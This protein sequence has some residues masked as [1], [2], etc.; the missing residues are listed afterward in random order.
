MPSPFRRAAVRAGRALDRVFGEEFRVTPYGLPPTLSGSPT[1]V[2]VRRALDPSRQVVTFTGAFT[3]ADEEYKTEGRRMPQNAARAGVAPRPA[4]DVARSALP[5]LPKE[6][7]RIERLETGE[8]F[9][10]GRT[11]ADDVGRVT[12]LL[13]ERQVRS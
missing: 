8:T 6:G 4:I 3:S 11:M 10:V 5:Y 12:I 1:D 9:D 13:T 2:N 7:D